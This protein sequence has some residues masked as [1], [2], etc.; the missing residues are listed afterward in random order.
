MVGNAFCFAFSSSAKH[1]VTRLMGRSVA[2][3]YTYSRADGEVEKLKDCPYKLFCA[4]LYLYFS[5]LRE[6]LSCFDLDSPT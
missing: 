1:Q 5:F 6:S 3:V 4:V 2:V